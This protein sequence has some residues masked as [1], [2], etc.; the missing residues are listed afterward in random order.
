MLIQWNN[1]PKVIY[2]VTAGQPSHKGSQ[3]DQEQAFGLT[4]LWSHE[5]KAGILTT[6]MKHEAV[7]TQEKGPNYEK[8]C[9]G[10]PC[11]GWNLKQ[12]PPEC[13][14]TKIFSSMYRVTEEKHKDFWSWYKSFVQGSY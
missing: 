6:T 1:K 13:Y 8:P 9:T 3:S 4:N 7:Y 2:K 5:Y 10:Y 12:G 14:K 11:P